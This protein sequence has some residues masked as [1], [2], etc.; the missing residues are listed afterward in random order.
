MQLSRLLLIGATVLVIGAI[1]AIVGG[2]GVIGYYQCVASSSPACT[3]Q[4]SDQYVT[5][6]LA[7]NDILNVGLNLAFMGIQISLVGILAVY[8]FRSTNELKT[9][10]ASKR[11]CPKC[12]GTIPDTAK[13]CANRGNKFGE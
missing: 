6:F 13:F 5:V 12:G 11:T 4:S 9:S 10:M 3:S 1:T 2:I 7:N 8:I